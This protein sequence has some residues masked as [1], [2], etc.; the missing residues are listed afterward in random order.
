MSDD[1][2]YSRFAC[3]ALTGLLSQTEATESGYPCP[4]WPARPDDADECC[5]LSSRAFTVA[6]AMEAEYQARLKAQ[7]AAFYRGDHLQEKERPQ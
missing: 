5:H 7:K 3:A 2:R 1:E 4:A 6:D